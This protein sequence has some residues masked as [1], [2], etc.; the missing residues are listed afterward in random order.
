[1]PAVTA[2]LNAASAAEAAPSVTAI[3][4]GPCEPTSPAAGVPERRPVTVS[5][6][7]QD[8]V[9][10]IEKT[11]VCPSGSAACGTNS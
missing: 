3:V 8:G 5:N 7:A 6:E 2:M 4:I 9:P 11:R 1:M 10:V